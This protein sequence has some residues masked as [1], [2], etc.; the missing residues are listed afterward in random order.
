MSVATGVRAT[1]K[2]G[3]H[4]YFELVQAFPLRHLRSD[5]ELDEAIKVIN[6]LIVRSSLSRG[7]QDY[8]DVLTDIVERYETENCPMSPVSDAEMLRHL[9]EAR[10]VTQ[11]KLSAEVAIPM[12]TIS[13]ILHGKKKLTRRQVGILATYFSVD[14]GV[15]LG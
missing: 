4:H 2:N 1:D 7:E 3:K 14:P 5:R 8:L 13:E 6:S 12:S 11:A 10:G 15:F 9:I